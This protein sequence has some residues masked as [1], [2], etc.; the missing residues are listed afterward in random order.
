M[1]VHIREDGWPETIPWPGEGEWTT[2][3]M[4]DNGG[5]CCLLGWM[6]VAFTGQPRLRH[7]SPQAKRALDAC[8]RDEKRKAAALAF[9]EELHK[10]CSRR[11]FV[12]DGFRSGVAMFN[13]DPRT[14]D[15]DRTAVWA[16]AAAAC[17]GYEEPR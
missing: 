16:E 1:K 12:D 10:A 2:F 8:G 14:T 6:Y 11:G 5:R 17:C 13:N 3:A 7:H 15:A 4:T 9:Q